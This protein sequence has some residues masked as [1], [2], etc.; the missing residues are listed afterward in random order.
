MTS[1]P[2]KLELVHPNGD[3]VE[4]VDGDEGIYLTQGWEIA[5]KAKSDS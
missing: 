4:V 2:K 1:K 5:G 3:K